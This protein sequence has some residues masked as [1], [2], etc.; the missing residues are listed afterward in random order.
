MNSYLINLL[1]YSTWMLSFKIYHSSYNYYCGY[2]TNFG[3]KGLPGFP[4]MAPARNKTKIFQSKKQKN[5]QVNSNNQ[6]T[7]Y[8]NPLFNRPSEQVRLTGV[9]FESHQKK[10]YIILGS[11]GI[12]DL[13]TSL[14]YFKTFFFFFL[15]IAWKVQDNKWCQIILRYICLF[16]F[17]SNVCVCIEVSIQSP[18][19][20]NGYVNVWR[21]RQTYCWGRRQLLAKIKSL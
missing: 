11:M 14:E 10:S 2:I 20:Q 17:F 1:W 3:W 19:G 9:K 8:E 4:E 6:I 18:A 5:P 21:G 16:V 13:S 15:L 7:R 12:I